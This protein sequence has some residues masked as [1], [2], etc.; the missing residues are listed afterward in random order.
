VGEAAKTEDARLHGGDSGNLLRAV[1]WDI[2]EEEEGAAEE[3][4]HARMEAIRRKIAGFTTKLLIGRA[5]SWPG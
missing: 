2:R 4:H 3:G 1:G 5:S